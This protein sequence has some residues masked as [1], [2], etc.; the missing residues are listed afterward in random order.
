M[1]GHL[2]RFLGQPG[3]KVD[4]LKVTLIQHKFINST[5]RVLESGNVIISGGS[6]VG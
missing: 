5:R 3:G 6:A 1:S 2:T 4:F